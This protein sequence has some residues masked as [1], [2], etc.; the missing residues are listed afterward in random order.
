MICKCED[1]D[2]CR[3]NGACRGG[4]KDAWKSDLLS[5]YECEPWCGNG[6]CTL[7]MVGPRTAERSRMDEMCRASLQA[8]VVAGAVQF[9]TTDNGPAVRFPSGLQ[10]LVRD[11]CKF[12][13]G[14][15]DCAR[16]GPHFNSETRISEFSPRDVESVGKAWA[17]SN[18]KLP[19]NTDVLLHHGYVE[20]DG[21]SG[22][23]Y[24][25][26]LAPLGVS[27]TF[28][29]E[30]IAVKIKWFFSPAAG[31][32]VPV[33]SPFSPVAVT[34]VAIGGVGVACGTGQ[35]KSDTGSYQRVLEV[36]TEAD[37][38]AIDTTRERCACEQLCEFTPAR[39]AEAFYW[40][41]EE[42][43]PPVPPAGYVVGGYVL[44]AR[45]KVRRCDWLMTPPTWKC[46][47]SQGNRV[48]VAKFD[49][50]LVV[51]VPRDVRA[52]GGAIPFLA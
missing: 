37:P 10:I 27:H 42:L 51:P 29:L 5:L 31:G 1:K 52:A 16:F 15:D 30:E 49:E 4:N 40:Q 36:P 20:V 45:V 43:V 21:A 12:G 19:L 48:S 35:N 50:A 22:K 38:E 2:N 39:G 25:G 32:E 6:G 26:F 24:A 14:D 46:V 34:A 28:C 7:S 8:L 9:V 33:E 13:C 47:N 41:L 18:E 17:Y 23:W 44:E 3:C 11:F